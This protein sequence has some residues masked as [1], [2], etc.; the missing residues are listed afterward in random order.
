MKVAQQPTALALAVFLA[1]NLSA[2]FQWGQSD[3]TTFAL[4]WLDRQAGTAYLEQHR[5]GYSTEQEAREYQ[6]QAG[7][8]IRDLLEARGARPDFRGLA[9]ARPGDF[10]LV[11]DEAAG[12]TRCHICTGLN[13]AS[14]WPGL[15]FAMLPMSSLPADVEVYR[16]GAPC[17][18]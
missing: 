13:F 4:D 5:G 16:L 6:A 17:R 12:W 14:I 8:T 1:E 15:G 18:R 9:F 2:Q 10:L 3:C 7:Y 11:E